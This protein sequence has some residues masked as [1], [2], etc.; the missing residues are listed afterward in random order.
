MRDGAIVNEGEKIPGFTYK[1]TG[2]DLTNRLKQKK[3]LANFF[4]RC[5]KEIKIG[6]KIRFLFTAN[7]KLLKSLAEIPYDSNIVIVSDSPYF[8]GIIKN[9]P[10]TKFQRS[11]DFTINHDS[12]IYKSSLRLRNMSEIEHFDTEPSELNIIDTIESKF[13]RKNHSSFSPRRKTLFITELSKGFGDIRR[14]SIEKPIRIVNVKERI[15]SK[16]DRQ[17]LLNRLKLRLGQAA[18]LIDQKLPKLCQQGSKHLM[19]K[20]NFGITQLHKLYAKYKMLVLLSV[21]RDLDHDISQGIERSIF[22][23]CMKN[24]TD[25]G[26]LV[27]SRVFDLIDTNKN[28]FVD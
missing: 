28:G 9:S 15:K 5:N 21:A 2:E 24:G 12:P 7:G 23:D 13:T 14:K 27:L 1:I 16:E 10:D 25:Q 3:L 22:I 4:D 19:K 8:I 18:L 6:N 20:Y 17:H 26:A 11:S